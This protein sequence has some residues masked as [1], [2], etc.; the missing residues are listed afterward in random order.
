M[1]QSNMRNESW[2]PDKWD[3]LVWI[4]RLKIIIRVC[5][6]KSDAFFKKNGFTKSGLGVSVILRFE[7]LMYLL[8][9][10]RN[11]RVCRNHWRDCAGSHRGYSWRVRQ[12]TRWYKMLVKA[13]YDLINSRLGPSL[14][15]QSL[16]EPED[17]Y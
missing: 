11:K 2:F 6:T 1:T 16:K 12:R 8:H 4:E 5:G 3:F 14:L 10:C 7:G 17:F 13:I 9:K 15:K